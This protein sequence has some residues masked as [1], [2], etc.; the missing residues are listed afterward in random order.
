MIRMLA[1]WLGEKRRGMSR[2]RTVSLSRT[3][4]DI[5]KLALREGN[6]GKRVNE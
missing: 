4:G 6:L 3:S 5:S 1:K 2:G